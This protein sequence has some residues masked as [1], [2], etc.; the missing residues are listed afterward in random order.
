LTR[1]TA[2]VYPGFGRRSPP[3]F[4]ANSH[5]GEGVKAYT[6]VLTILLIALAYPARA[7]DLSGAATA[8]AVVHLQK[9]QQLFPQAPAAT[10][11]PPSKLPQY[12]TNSDDEGSI[13]T[14]QPNGATVIPSTAFFQNLGTNGRTCFTCHQPQNGW[15][16]S[17]DSAQ[18]RFAADPTDPLFRL[19]DGATCPSDDVSLSLLGGSGWAAGGRRTPGE[20]SAR[21]ATD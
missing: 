21:T 10:Q 2:V 20:R 14:Y 1:T 12:Q 9:M 4:F 11:T 8:G 3:S 6:I 16:L 7:D 19:I 13:G 15:G 17:S 5:K 18:Q